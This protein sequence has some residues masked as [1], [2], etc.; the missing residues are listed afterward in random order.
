MSLKK[1][2][3]ISIS[4][5][6]AIIL[7]YFYLDRA[8]TEYAAELNLR[9]YQLL[10]FFSSIPVY[11]IYLSAVACVSAIARLIYKRKLEKWMVCSF[12]VAISLYVSSLAKN[13]LKFVFGRYWPATWKEGN[14]S[15]I[16]NQEYGFHPFHSGVWY[17]SFPSGH[18]TAIFASMIVLALF[19]PRLRILS[20][21]LIALTCIGQLGMY[22]HFVSDLIGGAYLGFVFGMGVVV[23]A[24]RFTVLEKL[25]NRAV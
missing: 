18:A 10:D 12:L 14:P 4:T 23:I 20:V 15:W 8:V 19:Y 21:L 9:Q 24:R 11:V 5:F 3:F 7:C 6:I 17:Q 2:L 22:Y 16:N 25:P 1:F 13:L